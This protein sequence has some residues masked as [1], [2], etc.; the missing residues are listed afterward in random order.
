MPTNRENM[1]KLEAL[2]LEETYELAKEHFNCKISQLNC[3]IVQ[4]PSKGFLGIGKKSAIIIASY[5][6]SKENE[7]LAVAMDQIQKETTTKIAASTAKKES[8]QPI[9][10]IINEE[11]KLQNSEQSK[12]DEI[13]SKMFGSDNNEKVFYNDKECSS[14]PIAPTQNIELS[15]TIED[16]IKRLFSL[17]CYHVDVVEVDIID[18]N[19]L[20]FIDGDDVALLIGKDG[21]RYN[22]ISYMLF[23][24]LYAKYELFVK[25]EIASFVTSQEEMIASML[26]PV[27]D[28][29]NSDGKGRTRPFKGILI[30]I[31]LTQLRV[32]FPSK[33][34]AIKTNKNGD[35]YII[36]N[37]FNS[38]PNE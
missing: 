13:D 30:Q 5:L 28:K 19:A 33:Y 37:D 22:A 9:V 20:I 8:P 25:L 6:P 32:A 4:Y 12:Y 3:E 17:S 23:N 38:K 1:K 21:Y 16:E 35:R 36:V 11:I 10:E 27:I 14:L 2:T 7:K 15:K 29:I 18:N 34:V 26:L 31:A 24:W